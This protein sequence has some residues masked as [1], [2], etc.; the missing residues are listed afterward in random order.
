M[1]NL[2]RMLLGPVS[3]R[4]RKKILIVC[5]GL[6]QYIPFNALPDPDRSDGALM[7]ANHEITQITSAAALIDHRRARPTEPRSQQ[8]VAVL[9]DPVFDA[10]DARLGRSARAQGTYRLKFFRQPGRRVFSQVR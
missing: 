5:N 6:L 7:I 9:A 8:L 3:K 1:P 4:L 10:K 2:G